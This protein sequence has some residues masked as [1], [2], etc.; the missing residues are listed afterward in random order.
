VDFGHGG[1]V[2]V[3]GEPGV[4]EVDVSELEAA[5]SGINDALENADYRQP[6]KEEVAPALAK[7]HEAYFNAEAGPAGPWA[8]LAQSTINAKGFDTILIENGNMRSSLLF[9]GAANHIE[10]V[11]EAGL[12]WGT[13]DPKAAFHMEGTRIMPAR[14]FV[15]VTDPLA[16]E[17]AEIIGNAAQKIAVGS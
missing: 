6:M 1:Q 3:P 7:A 17:I 15:G 12:T 5:Y 10:E 14:P 9:E 16:D 11:S 13:S 4:I 2:Q 8:P